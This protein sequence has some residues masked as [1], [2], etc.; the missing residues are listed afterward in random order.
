[1]PKNPR[2]LLQRWD[3]K[4]MWVVSWDS[5]GC[6]EKRWILWKQGRSHG[7]SFVS[8]GMFC[9]RSMEMRPE[10][11]LD[12]TRCWQLV[13]LCALGFSFSSMSRGVSCACLKELG[14]LLEGSRASKVGRTLQ[15]MGLP[16]SDSSNEEGTVITSHG[17][18][19]QSIPTP[20]QF[21]TYSAWWGGRW[22]VL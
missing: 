21:C 14:L 22:N 3:T 7:R 17:I 15:P 9:P 6:R 1:M 18:S 12:Q 19:D 20:W 11:S 8:A 4:W 5:Q 2:V 10:Q 16:P 13:G